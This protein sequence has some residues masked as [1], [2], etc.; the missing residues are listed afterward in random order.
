TDAGPIEYTALA[1][2]ADLDGWLE[3]FLQLEQ[4]GWKGKLGGALAANDARRS[5]FL[6]V[7]QEAWRRGRLMMLALKHNGEVIA[8]KCNFLAGDGS[9][10]FK[11]AYNEAYAR[12]SPGFFLELENIRR[13]HDAPEIRWM[14]SCA[15]PDHPMINRLWLDRRTIQTVL[16][17]TGKRPGE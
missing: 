7:A 11:I 14:D 6:T 15:V 2:D 10:A 8:Q 16:I 5:Y 9:F 17:P 3:E 1:T 13:L 4:A 12:Y